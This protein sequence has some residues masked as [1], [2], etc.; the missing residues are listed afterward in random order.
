MKITIKGTPQELAKII[1]PSAAMHP[2]QAAAN[3]ADTI[4]AIVNE[5]DHNKITPAEARLRLE[6]ALHTLS[7]GK[8]HA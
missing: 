7:K 4:H 5:L 8:I 1:S 6:I 2:S 3:A